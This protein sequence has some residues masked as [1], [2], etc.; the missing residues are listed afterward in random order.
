[1]F[2]LL[3]SPSGINQCHYFEV[4]FELSNFI[5]SERL[6]TSDY[7]DYLATMR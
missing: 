3:K 2:F 7:R 5:N 4:T 6:P 1:M